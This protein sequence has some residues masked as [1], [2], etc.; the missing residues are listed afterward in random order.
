[1]KVEVLIMED[2]QYYQFILFKFYLLLEYDTRFLN[3]QIYLLE[4]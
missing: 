4:D 1:M 3:K 2:L